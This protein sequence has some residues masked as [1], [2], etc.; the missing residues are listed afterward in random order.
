MVRVTSADNKM[1]TKDSDLVLGT[2]REEKDLGVWTDERLE[3]DG[4]ITCICAKGNQ[5]FGLVK[6]TFI[7]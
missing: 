5:L 7:Y 3:F 6:R 2:C 4:H 1:R